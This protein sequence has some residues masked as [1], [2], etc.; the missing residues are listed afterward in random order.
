MLHRL[1]IPFCAKAAVQPPQVAA[2]TIRAAG[3]PRQVAAGTIRA[4][5]QPRR[6]AAATSIVVRAEQV[7]SGMLSGE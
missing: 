2:A 3:R 7:H 6:V 4:A 1:I 5:A